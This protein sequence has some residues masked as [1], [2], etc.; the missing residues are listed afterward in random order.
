MGLAATGPLVARAVPARQEPVT[1]NFIT[2]SDEWGEN[3]LAAV[4]AFGLARS[5]QL[6]IR[7]VIGMAL[8]FAYFVAD[9]FAL[10]MGNF[11]AYPPLLAAWAPFALF[12]LIGETVLI[13]TEE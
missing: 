3:M 10:A 1:L 7:A 8:G 12:L 6:A 11:G 2:Q 5:G 13:R 9:N 4:A